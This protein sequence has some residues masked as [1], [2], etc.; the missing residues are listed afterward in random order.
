[1]ISTVYCLD[2][3][4]EPDKEFHVVKDRL[5]PQYGGSLNYDQVDVREAGSSLFN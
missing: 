2:R 3:L 5:G 4:E 1:M